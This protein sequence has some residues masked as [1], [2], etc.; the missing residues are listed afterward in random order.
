ML[1]LHLQSPATHALE[2]LKVT[3]LYASRHLVSH[4][5]YLFYYTPL[6]SLHNRNITLR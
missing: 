4:Y 6:S 2:S 1:L 3:F 5:T